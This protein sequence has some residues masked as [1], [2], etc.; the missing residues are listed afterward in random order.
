MPTTPNC[1]IVTGPPGSGKSTL[2]KELSKLL[3]LP[4]VSRDEIKEGYVNTFNVPHDQL[5]PDSNAHATNIFFDT[6]SFL[7]SKKISLIAE[8]AFQHPLWQS[9]I[10]SL[11]ALSNVRIILCS[12]PPET[13]AHR[14]L[15]RGLTDPKRLFYHGDKRVQLFRDQG[16]LQPPADY[17]P[18]KFDLPTLEVSTLNGYSPPLTTLHDFAATA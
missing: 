14:H 18:P 9:R 6:L 12:L 2:S 1:L 7:L 16:I 8:A 11:I 4:I 10:D 3:Y 15:Q 5:P 13:A 17:D